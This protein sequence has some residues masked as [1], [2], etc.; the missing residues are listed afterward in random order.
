MSGMLQVGMARESG[1][2]VAKLDGVFEKHQERPPGQKLEPGTKV[3][4][5]S[6]T[7]LACGTA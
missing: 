2:S 4:R 7:V 3:R 1:P 5:G 6:G